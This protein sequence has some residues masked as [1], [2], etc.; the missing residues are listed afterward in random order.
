MRQ[1]LVKFLRPFGGKRHPFG[2][3]E[4]DPTLRRPQNAAA[5]FV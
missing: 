1:Q 3:A 2:D 5:K 4:R